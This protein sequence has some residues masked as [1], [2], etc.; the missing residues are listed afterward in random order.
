MQQQVLCPSC[1]ALATAY[2]VE[3]FKPYYFKGKLIWSNESG[4]CCQ[5]CGEFRI[6]TCEEPNNSAWH[7][8]NERIRNQGLEFDESLQPMKSEFC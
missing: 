3:H 8:E 6:P 2:S 4:Y 1:L 5:K 7:L